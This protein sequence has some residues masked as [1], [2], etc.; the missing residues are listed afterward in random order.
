MS[1]RDAHGTGHRAAWLAGMRRRGS[2]R[3]AGTGSVGGSDGRQ[4]FNPGRWDNA[5]DGATDGHGPQVD[6][7]PIAGGRVA[8]LRRASLQG[9]IPD[10]SRVQRRSRAR[11]RRA[12]AIYRATMSALTLDQPGSRGLLWTFRN[13]GR[14]ASVAAGRY[15]GGRSG[16]RSRGQGGC[17]RRPERGVRLATRRRCGTPACP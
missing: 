6:R 12:A 14:V 4:C 11:R 16:A 1:C 5:A 13:V 9:G 8:R 10:R 17:K 2:D 3:P 7:S 15:A